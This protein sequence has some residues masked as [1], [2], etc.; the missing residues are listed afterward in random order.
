[1]PETLITI[2]EEIPTG[3]VDLKYPPVPN[4][5]QV[6]GRT[7]GVVIF[8]PFPRRSEGQTLRSSNQ[9]P[10]GRKRR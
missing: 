6:L 3:I 8:D 7:H 4:T 5:W 10:V 9:A 1:M 2:L